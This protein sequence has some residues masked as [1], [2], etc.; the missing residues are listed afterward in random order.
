MDKSLFKKIRDNIPDS[1]KRLTGTAFRQLLLKNKNFNRTLKVLKVSKCLS[2]V[3]IEKNQL[4]KIKSVLCYADEFVPYYK[5][6]F[7]S[8]NFQ[9]RKM[10]SIE[11]IQVIPFLTKE[12]IRNN[13]TQLV[14]NEK[15]SGGY[16][17]TTTG[18]SSGDALDIIHD[19]NSIFKEYAFVYDFRKRHGYS[20]RDKLVT[21]RGG[22]Y[23]KK[24]SK[25]NPL[26]NELLVS[27]FK[28]SKETLPAYNRLIKGFK[29]GFL[30]GYLSAIYYYARLL[31]ASNI[32]L[33]LNLKGI[34]YHSE[35]IDPHKREFVENFFGVKSYAFYGHAERCVF[36]E[37]ISPGAYTFNPEY[38]YTELFPNSNGNFNIVGTGFLNRKM[39]LIRYLTDDTCADNKDGT[40]MVYGRRN[41]KNFLIGK[42]FERLYIS[43]FCYLNEIFPNISHYQ[44][45]QT[46]PGY[47]ELHIV[48][49][50]KLKYSFIKAAQREVNKRLTGILEIK[51]R[52]V[53]TLTLTQNGKCPSI[54][55]E[56]N[57]IK[58]I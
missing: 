39:P 49:Y 25:L 52:P 36:G 54:I 26:H 6:L 35:N 37:E 10:S 45:K 44:L 41:S 47:C 18:G 28:L 3:E 16:Y 31:S 53:K 43:S 50:S 33:K 34:F 30:N 51:V 1:L 29:P 56:C 8:V 19:Y 12:I 32:D 7:A 20:Y 38:G 15:I 2:A 5:E 55:N 13:F 42:N 11:E 4:K 14:S 58:N 22:D 23:H 17:R 27:P 40:F 46:E 57:Q 48:P 9:P 24:F 21:F